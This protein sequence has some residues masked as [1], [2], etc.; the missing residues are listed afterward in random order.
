[1]RTVGNRLS[2]RLEGELVEGWYVLI[3]ESGEIPLQNQHL[4]QDPNEVKEHAK[5]LSE[6][7]CSLQRS[8][9]LPRPGT[10]KERPGGQWGWTQ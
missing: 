5:H 10:H 1:M 3:R 9:H 7:M 8:Q 2:R 4:S 6:E